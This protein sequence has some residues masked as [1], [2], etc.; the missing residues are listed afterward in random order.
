L[1]VN[2]VAGLGGRVGLKGSDDLVIQQR[3][4]RLGAKPE[5]GIRTASALDELEGLRGRIEIVTYPGEMGAE[6]LVSRGFRVK[7]IGAIKSGQTTSADTSEAAV[8]MERMGAQLLLFAGGDGTARDIYDAVGLGQP[9]LGIPAGVK[10][11]SAVFGVG[12]RSAGETARRFLER[13]RMQLREREVMDIDEAA[14]RRGRVSARLYGFLNVPYD[15]RLV[16]CKKM[17]NP[18]SDH[19]ALQEI[20]QEVVDLMKPDLLYLLGPGTTTRAIATRLGIPKTLTGVDVVEK[21]GLI[22]TDVSESELLILVAGRP[23]GVIVAP[24]GGQGFLFGRG[25]QQISP[26]VLA[27][28][29]RDD[30]ICISTPGKLA[31]LRGRPLLV[32]TGDRRVDRALAG[33]IPIITGYQERVVYRVEG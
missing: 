2:P 17:P 33:Y 18:P 21:S 30:I 25:N 16:Q 28:I 7:V 32:D 3:A 23:A 11:H 20:A 8:Q 31:E 5:A 22:A 1:I 24:I 10:I 6:A 12:P 15:D 14:L 26:A 13:E 9:V 4:R 19:L 27:A 29:Q